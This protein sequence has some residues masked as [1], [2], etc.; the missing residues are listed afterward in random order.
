MSKL[1]LDLLVQIYI[2]ENVDKHDY[3]PHH[4]IIELYH[5]DSRLLVVQLYIRRRVLVEMPH[6]NR[7]LIE[8]VY[9]RNDLIPLVRLLTPQK[10]L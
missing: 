9:Q 2:G 6:R 5:V 8:S 7:Y 3:H 1:L 4:E 10:D